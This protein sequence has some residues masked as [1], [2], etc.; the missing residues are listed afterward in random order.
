MVYPKLVRRAGDSFRPAPAWPGGARCVVLITIDFDGPSNEVG[1]GL[2]PLGSDSAGRYSGRRGVQ[3]HLDL[4]DTHKIRAA[5]FVPGYDAQCYPDVVREIAQRGHEIGAHGYLHEGV[6]LPPEEEKRR[7]I[8]THEILSGLTGRPPLG[9]RSPSGQKTQ[10]TLSVLQS[11]DYIYSSSDKDADAPYLLRSGRRRPMVAIPNNTFS[12]DDFP[13]YK[14]SMTPVSE[15]LAQ[16]RQEFDAIYADRG[17]F[18]LTVHPR[19]GWGSGTPSRSAALGELI[20]YIRQHSGVFFTTPSEL[21]SW[22]LRH[23]GDF[24]ELEVSD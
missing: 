16:W 11:L 19:S 5:F 23:A 20:R 15:V 12:L 6:L 10:N 24:D 17:Y 2:R 4:L 14:F 18:M 8:Q 3:R 22:C 7:L 21:A 9:W 1:K 13:W